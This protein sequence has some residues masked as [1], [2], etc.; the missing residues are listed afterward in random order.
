M[1]LSTLTYDISLPGL[2]IDN[3][4]ILMDYPA[5]KKTE[6][7]IYLKLT[8]LITDENSPIVKIEKQFKGIVESACAYLKINDK[9]FI[10]ALLVND[11]KNKEVVKVFAMQDAY[12]RLNNSWEFQ[13]WYDDIYQYHEN[14]ILIRTSVDPSDK[15]FEAKSKIKQD[16]RKSQKE[17]AKDIVSLENQIFPRGTNIKKVLTQSVAKVTTWPER[18]AKAYSSPE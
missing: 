5:F 10:Y 18:M 11:T 7:D 4:P 6:D 17:L 16:I 13:T 1:D 8:I 2:V 12:F 9:D 14:S 3:Y 15:S